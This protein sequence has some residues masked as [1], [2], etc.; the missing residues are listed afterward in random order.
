[1]SLIQHCNWCGADDEAVSVGGWLV[2]GSCGRYGYLVGGPV[3]GRVS[4][5][6]PKLSEREL[7]EEM[8]ADGELVLDEHLR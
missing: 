6:N 2:C 7:E 1:M 3:E 4:T 5:S 8:L